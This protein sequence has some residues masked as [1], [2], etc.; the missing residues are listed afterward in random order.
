MAAT[1][2]ILVVAIG[3][4]GLVTP[5]YVKPGATVIDV[6]MNRVD[7]PDLVARWFPEG[8]SRRLE[9]ERKGSLLVGDV[10][11]AV[12]GVAGALT[13]VPGGVGP[14]TS[15]M[16]MKNTVIAAEQRLGR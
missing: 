10:E 5:V 9:F 11:P 8:S 1:A 2:D 6:G 12:A 16:L 13:P 3:R 14:L 15:A 4:A 7:D